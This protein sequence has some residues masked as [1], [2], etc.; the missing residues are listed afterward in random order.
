M[1]WFH[2]RRACWL[3]LWYS[4]NNNAGRHVR[5]RMKLAEALLQDKPIKRKG[6]KMWCKPEIVKSNRS[7]FASLPTVC[8]MDKYTLD[9]N[10]M[11]ADDWEVKQ[12]PMSFEFECQFRE[13]PIGTPEIFNI[14][15]ASLIIFDLMKSGKRFKVTCVEVED[16]NRS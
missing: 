1:A 8:G 7:D 13:S 15:A 16:A 5:F 9:Y 12:E 4:S 14:I 6:F 10:N 2:H 3:R 11:T